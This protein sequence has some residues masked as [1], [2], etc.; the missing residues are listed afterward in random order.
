MRFST[1]KGQK[2]RFV[3]TSQP[4]LHGKTITNR[5][6]IDLTHEPDFFQPNSKLNYNQ[7]LLQILVIK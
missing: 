3:F 6:A 7:L 1:G 4:R 2:I 5:S